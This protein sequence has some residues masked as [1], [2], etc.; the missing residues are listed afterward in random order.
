MVARKLLII[1]AE[2]LKDGRVE[3]A[4]KQRRKRLEDARVEAA[5]N[6]RCKAKKMLASKLL[7]IG[8][9]RLERC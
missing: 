4:D 6:P 2:R 1:S 9:E 7:I 5:D 8:A 3:A